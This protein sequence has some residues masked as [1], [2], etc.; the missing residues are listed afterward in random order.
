MEGIAVNTQQMIAA[1]VIQKS[2]RN[3]ELRKQEQRKM[4]DAAFVDY[5]HRKKMREQEY[6]YYGGMK[7]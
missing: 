4:F 7:R 3:E 6:K 5:Q 1:Q 2:K